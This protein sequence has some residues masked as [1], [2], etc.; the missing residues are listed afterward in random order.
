[1]FNDEQVAFLRKLVAETAKSLPAGEAQPTPEAAATDGGLALK[2]DA[3]GVSLKS[4]LDRLEAMPA[5]KGAGYFTDDG[6]SADA[7]HKSFGDF[8]LAVKRGDKVRLTKIYQSRQAEEVWGE[9]A[10]KDMSGD[11]GS[12]GGYL[13]PTEYIPTLMQAAGYASVVRPRATVIPVMSS[14]GELPALDLSTAPTAGVG[15]SAFAGGVV[16]TWAG[17]GSAGSETQPK[18]KLIEYNIRKMAGYT[19][20]PNEVIAEAMGVEALL[21]AL[22]GRA[23]SNMEDYAFIRGSGAGQPQGILSSPAAIGV[24]TTTNNV[25]AYADALKML[26]RFKGLMGPPAWLIHPGMWPDIGA[27]EVSAGSGGVFQSNLAGAMAL[28]L[29]GYPILESEHMPA[30]DT[31]DVILADLKS[32]VIF[33]RAGIAVSFSEHAAFTADK[34]TWRVTKRLDGKPW[35]TGPI[36]LADPGGATTVSPFCYHDD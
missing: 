15:N 22:F 4:V 1:M 8:L 25:F 24:T 26:A 3:M 16:V 6:G 35:L 2:V 33:D 10:R 17:E 11:L 13:I 12:A 18:F 7:S 21:S 5:L 19:E 29:L 20:V 9:D 23:V 36:T 27:F 34:G 14:K 30:P 32:Y 28:T 31:D